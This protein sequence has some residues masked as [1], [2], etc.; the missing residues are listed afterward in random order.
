MN[1]IDKE[2]KSIY[3]YNYSYSI[4]ATTI[5][6]SQETK[7]LLEELKKKDQ[8]KTYDEVIQKLA[9]KQLRIPRSMFGA[10]KKIT[11]WKKEDR[12]AFREL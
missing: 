8:T 10:T 5:Q 1:T 3:S 2:S 4:M 6:V 7:Q 12:A 9:Q 11:P